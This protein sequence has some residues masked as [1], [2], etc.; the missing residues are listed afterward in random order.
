M[1]A[2]LVGHLSL[3]G[4]WCSAI[5]VSPPSSHAPAP[6]GDLAAPHLTKV[7]AP[8][9]TAN[10][11]T[12]GAPN[13]SA[14]PPPGLMPDEKSKQL[15]DAEAANDSLSELAFEAANLS[16]GDIDSNN[17]SQITVHEAA[18]FSVRNGVPWGDI[19]PIFDTVD[20]NHDHIITKEEFL[21]N[22]GEA[23]DVL[24]DLRARFRDIDI[25]QDGF[26]SSDEWMAYCD[27]WMVSNISRETCAH[28]F[29]A[30]DRNEPKGAI[31]R[32]EFDGAGAHCKGIDD[33]NCAGFLSLTRSTSTRFLGTARSKLVSREPTLSAPKLFGD[34]LRQHRQRRVGS[35]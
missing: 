21:A 19:K 8:N 24:Q 35:L 14:P 28:M 4:V 20:T 6:V 22:H 31:D 7:A 9:S 25:N 30:A 23:S 34:A 27:G 29:E 1:A 17:D 3:L 11:S 32:E 10:N 12:Q 13:A 26:V 2:R 33:G 5:T 16:F 15:R 18:T